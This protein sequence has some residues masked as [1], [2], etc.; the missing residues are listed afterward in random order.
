[1]LLIFLLGEDQTI[2]NKGHFSEARISQELPT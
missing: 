2:E 1:M